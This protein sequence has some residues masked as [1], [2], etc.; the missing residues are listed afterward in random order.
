MIPA[1]RFSP[2]SAAQLQEYLLQE[3]FRT[4]GNRAPMEKRW[5]DWQDKYRMRPEFEQKDFPFKNCSNM[6]VGLIS[7]DVDTIHARLMAMLHTPPNLWTMTPMRPEMELF[8]P[9]LEEFIQWAQDHELMMYPVT[10]DWIMELCKLGTSVL[11][12]RYNRE[13]KKVYEFREVPSVSQFGAPGGVQTLEQQVRMLVKDSPQVSHVSLPDFY[14]PASA[15]TI[16]NAPWCAE[17]IKLTW[18]QLVNR[19]NAGIYTNVQSLSPFVG[20]SQGTFYEKH[21][22]ELDR[23]KVSLGDRTELFEFWLDWDIDGDGEQEAIVT[24]LH[25][26]SRISLR[27]DFNPFFNQEKPYDAAR[28]L[29]QE[30]RFYGIGIAEMDEAY[31][32][33]MSTLHNQRIDNNT[34]ANAQVIVALKTGNIRQDEPIYPGRVLLVDSLDELRMN[35]FGTVKNQ[36]TIPDEEFTLQ[37][38]RQRTGVNDYISGASGT[39]VGYSAATTAVQQLRE[40]AKRFDQVLREVRQALTNVG[41]KVVELYQQFNQGGKPFLAMGQKDGQVV[42]QILQFPLQIIRMG[43][44][45]DVTA[46]SAAY[47]RET[48]IR[49]NTIILQM[50]TQFYAQAFQAMQIV[51]NPQLP[52]PLRMMMTKAIQGG[53]ILMGRI[54]DDYGV[55]DSENMLPDLQEMLGVAQQQL[56]GF[57]AGQPGQPVGAIQQPGFGQPAMGQIAGGSPGM[58]N[59]LPGFGGTQVGAQP[60]AYNGNGSSGVVPF[61]R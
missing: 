26:D 44:G 27:L 5:L 7:S 43:V 1:N 23:F 18:P 36:S 28:Y 34:I 10:R 16:S 50:L 40:G 55:Q 17:S 59:L 60:Q 45:I 6:V 61:A 33:E 21:M 8:A 22:Q 49:T 47:N 11:K 13:M 29:P 31:Q 15:T 38:A 19:A 9:R 3:I 52:V 2:Q 39:D 42:Q 12:T 48:E 24:T 25:Y 57:G 56:N 14:I 46:T 32:D 53:V 41:T 20:R 4:R 54:L 37:L 51:L 58:A 30:N 35:S